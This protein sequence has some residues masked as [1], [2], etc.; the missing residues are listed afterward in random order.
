M[1]PDLIRHL[2]H[3]YDARFST[4]LPFLAY[5]VNLSE[6]LS[7]FYKWAGVARA[8]PESLRRI[9]KILSHPSIHKVFE[10]AIANPHSPLAVALHT[11][12]SSVGAVSTG[13]AGLS[14]KGIAAAAMAHSRDMFCFETIAPHP[15][16][17]PHLRYALAGKSNLVQDRTA[18][19]DPSSLA[20][21]T[22]AATRS[23]LLRKDHTLG[24]R[25]FLDL[26]EAV[27]RN[28]TCHPHTPKCTPF[29][30]L[31][32]FGI[33]GQHGPSFSMRE[34]QPSTGNPHDHTTHSVAFNH[35]DLER[36]AA[37]PELDSLV[38][39]LASTFSSSDLPLVPPPPPDA[40]PLQ[41]SDIG[42]TPLFDITE[43]ASFP[44]LDANG[45][46]GP[47]LSLAHQLHRLLCVHDPNHRPTCF[48]CGSDQCRLGFPR[49]LCD[50][51]SQHYMVTMRKGPN[52]EQQEQ[53]QY[54]IIELTENDRKQLNVPRDVAQCLFRRAPGDPKGGTFLFLLE[55]RGAHNKYTGET[56]MFLTPVVRCN[57][58]L[59][60]TIGHDSVLAA[61][62]YCI[63]YVMPAANKAPAVA[64]HLSLISRAVAR[65]A[66][67][68]TVAPD[69]ETDPHRR[70]GQYVLTLADMIEIGSNPVS[71]KDNIAELL[72]PGGPAVF[73]HSVAF[74]DTTPFV[75]RGDVDDDEDIDPEEL[76][77]Q[78]PPLDLAALAGAGGALGA[79]AGVGAPGVVFDDEDSRET[80]LMNIDENGGE[81]AWVSLL[82]MAGKDA[83]AA[84]ASSLKTKKLALTADGSRFHTTE[85]DYRWRGPDLKDLSPLAYSC[86]VVL[87]PNREDEGQAGGAGTGAGR[88]RAR[89][90]AFDPE[91]PLHGTHSQYIS[92]VVKLPVLT[93][94]HCPP[95][96]GPRPPE[97]DLF[98]TDEAR[99]AKAAALTEWR[100]IGSTFA[101]YVL[102]LILPR[103]PGH[104]RPQPATAYGQLVKWIE[105]RDTEVASPLAQ[106]E[107]VFM[108]SIFMGANKTLSQAANS[109]RNHAAD[110]LRQ[111]LRHGAAGGAAVGGGLAPG[112][113]VL[114]LEEAPPRATVREGPVGVSTRTPSPGSSSPTPSSPPTV[115]SRRKPSFSASSSAIRRRVGLTSSPRPS[116]T[117]PVPSAERRTPNRSTAAWLDAQSSRRSALSSPPFPV[118]PCSV[119]CR[120]MAMGA[121]CLPLR[122]VVSRRTSRPPS[123]ASSLRWARS[124]RWRS[125][126][127]SA[128][129]APSGSSK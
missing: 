91:H 105:E 46:A 106:L 1:S 36:M 93:G 33:R 12:L 74:I 127:W 8:T 101:C 37:N 89:R 72:R 25:Y 14:N 40:P 77:H 92:S 10:M 27:R 88:P 121:P 82:E 56:C 79:G 68:G 126:T 102:D 97:P 84:R 50:G 4:S 32:P 44:F 38:G 34:S 103:L 18:F 64:G 99:A 119:P 24:V 43:D 3:F 51:C 15:G 16:L 71:L 30:S 20:T 122:R 39:R 76:A 109:F 125:G 94:T 116:G 104:V 90:F 110:Y 29:I 70:H 83:S 75:E 112:L 69:H 86:L 81:Q 48:R 41:L 95:E 115:T 114:A 108:R 60:V 47:F 123:T 42:P 21:A 11:A 45:G 87:K 96:P 2:L 113:A 35:L 54:E 49:S 129:H 53:A 26:V 5:L 17:A 107:Y 63:K 23:G 31:N 67:R 22:D 80:Q 120:Q 52:H 117:L 128:R 9:G 19:M 57:T 6:R 61:A 118:R 78:P 58:N 7:S 13:R 55:H 73:S 124:S 65:A 111:D 98:D 59:S 66:E 62:Y 100:G 28:V 85:M